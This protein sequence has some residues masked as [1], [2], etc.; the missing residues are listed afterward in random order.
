LTQ[1]RLLAQL[2]QPFFYGLHFGFQIGQI[3]FQ[4]CNLLGPGLKAALE[5]PA[6]AAMA[7]TLAGAILTVALAVAAMVMA[8]VVMAVRFITF[9][10]AARTS[11]TAMMFVAIVMSMMM[12]VFFATHLCLPPFIL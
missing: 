12:P 4:I 5:P 8:P 3:A 9:T 1:A 2:G 6:L 10:F 11:L 7:I